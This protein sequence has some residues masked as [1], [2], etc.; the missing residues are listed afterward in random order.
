MPVAS[1]HSRIN[2]LQRGVRQRRELPLIVDNDD[3]VSSAATDRISYSRSFNDGPNGEAS[4]EHSDSF[5]SSIRP[6]WFPDAGSERRLSNV[7]PPTTDGLGR[8]K[9]SIKRGF[10]SDSPPCSHSPID[11]RLAAPIPL[12]AKKP[13]AQSSSPHNSKHILGADRTPSPKPEWKLKKK[14]SKIINMLVVGKPKRGRRGAR[15]SLGGSFGD[16]LLAIA[17]DL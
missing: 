7:E 1:H 4:T 3:D 5:S 9:M 14:T 8:Q 10:S 17:V 6:F 11:Q 16:L 13:N 15:H 2:Q 12:R